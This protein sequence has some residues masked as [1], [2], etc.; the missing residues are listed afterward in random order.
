MEFLTATSAYDLLIQT[1]HSSVITLTGDDGAEATTTVHE[2]T[3]GVGLADTEFGAGGAEVNV[4]QYGV[5]YDRFARI[6][7]AGSSLDASSS[8]YTPMCISV[9]GVV[10]TQRSAMLRPE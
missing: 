10:L 5:Y 6:D 8:P 2:L 9:N 4:E 1:P 7:D 3:R